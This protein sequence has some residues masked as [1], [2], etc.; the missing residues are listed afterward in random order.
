[1]VSASLNSADAAGAELDDAAV[2]D[3]PEPPWFMPG[4]LLVSELP[5]P[6]PVEQPARAMAAAT[7][8]AEMVRV[9]FMEIRVL[10]SISGA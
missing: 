4:M 10:K 9:F 1:M 7:A 8:A 2:L 6:E 5:A 3:V